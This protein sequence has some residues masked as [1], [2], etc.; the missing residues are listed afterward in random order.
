MIGP[1]KST[2]TP[3]TACDLPLESRVAERP[4]AIR[5]TTQIVEE[6]VFERSPKQRPVFLLPLSLCTADPV[7]KFVTGHKRIGCALGMGAVARPTIVRATV[8]A[9][10]GRLV[11]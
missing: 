8:A 3:I 4:A 7:V 10:H 5:R 2:L 11:G 9:R 6:S 1:R